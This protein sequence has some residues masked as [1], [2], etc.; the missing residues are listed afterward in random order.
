MKILSP[1]VLDRRTGHQKTL[2]G[3]LVE[4]LKNQ[5]GSRLFEIQKI[6]DIDVEVYLIRSYD[7]EGV[8]GC[9]LY[10]SQH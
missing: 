5:Q 1:V 6:G 2:G 10:T 8:K 4:I 3:L 7:L 9:L